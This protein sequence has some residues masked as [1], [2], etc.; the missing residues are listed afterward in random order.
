MTIE[1]FIHKYILMEQKEQKEKP[2]SQSSNAKGYL[3]QHPLFD[4]VY[5]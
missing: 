1:E 2:L 5:F 3:A 4:Q